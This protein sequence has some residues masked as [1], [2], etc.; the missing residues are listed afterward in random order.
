MEDKQYFDES[1]RLIA[2]DGLQRCAEG[3]DY[4]RK[5]ADCG[6]PVEAE[7]D[8]LARDKAFLEAFK[9]NFFPRGA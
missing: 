8:S 9:R 1:Y 6:L 7:Q 2:N 3:E 5:C 4:L